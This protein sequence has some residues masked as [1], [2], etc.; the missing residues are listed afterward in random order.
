MKKI[1]GALIIGAAF[2]GACSSSKTTVPQSSTTDAYLPKAIVYKADARYADL[3]PVTLNAAGN[4]LTSFPAP[5]D[6]SDNSTPVPLGDGW[7]LDRRGISPNSAFTSYTYDEYMKLTSVPSTQTLMSKIV[8]K[9]P[10][11]AMYRLPI[12]RNSAV[13][14]PALCKKFIKKKFKDCEALIP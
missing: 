1:L 5:S 3:V 10:F 7:Y 8:E 13:N 9:H 11:E 2:A 4:A 14:D 6:L 12:S